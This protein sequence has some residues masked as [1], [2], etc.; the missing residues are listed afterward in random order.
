MSINKMTSEV[1]MDILLLAAAVLFSALGSTILPGFYTRKNVGLRGQGDLYNLCRHLGILVFWGIYYAFNFSFEPAVLPYCLLIAIGYVSCFWILDAMACGPVS[2]TSLFVSLSLVVSSVYGFFF[3]N[4][5]VTPLSVA[6]LCLVVLSLW[7][8]LHKGRGQ[9]PV[10][11]KWLLLVAVFFTGNSAYSI[12]QRAQQ[13]AWNG[14]HRGQ[15][16]FFGLLLTC[17]GALLRYLVRRRKGFDKI[18]VK[19]VAIPFAASVINGFYNLF[20]MMLATR[21]LSPSIIYPSIAV[22]ALALTS[23]FSLAVLK[24]KMKWWQWLGIAVGTVAVGLLSI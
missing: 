2:L 20:V 14:E 16:M 4:S 22:G 18:P 15:L 9:A 8:A 24:E 10:S 6:G 5:P 17:V 19:T 21:P 13:A 11:R 3:W 23:L 1:F 7:L 12:G